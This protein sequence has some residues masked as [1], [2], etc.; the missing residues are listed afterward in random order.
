MNFLTS[1]VTPRA[2]VCNNLYKSN[3]VGI[4][5]QNKQNW[6]PEDCGNPMSS[7][8]STFTLFGE[9]LQGKFHWTEANEEFILNSQTFKISQLYRL[10]P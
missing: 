8:T 10:K 7:S 2:S 4:D 5:N 9:S 1:M 6:S 3:I